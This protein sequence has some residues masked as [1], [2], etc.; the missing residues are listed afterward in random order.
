M[1]S[2]AEK[3]KEVFNKDIADNFI[4]ANDKQTGLSEFLGIQLVEFSPGKVVAELKV[5]PELL[6]PFGNLHGGVMSAFTDHVLGCVCY[7][8]MKKGQWAATT[9]FKLNLLAPVSKGAVRAVAEIINMTRT[10][11]VVQIRMENDG[12]PCIAAQGTVLIMDPR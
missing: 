6:T 8:H 12:R 11:A 4:A 7:P 10:T 3:M 2:H 5:K 1:A 9:E